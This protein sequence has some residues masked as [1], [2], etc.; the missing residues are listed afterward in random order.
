LSR[1]KELET[2][3]L[4]HNDFNRSVMTSSSSLTSLRT[5][6]LASNDLMGYFPAEGIATFD[7]PY[8]I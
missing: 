6:I 8:E 4:G 7:I 2:L 1:L 3:D 5:L